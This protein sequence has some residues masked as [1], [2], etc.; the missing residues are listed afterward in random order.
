MWAGFL[1]VSGSVFVSGVVY[2]PNLRSKDP[3][4]WVGFWKRFF[5][6]VDCLQNC[7]GVFTGARDLLSIPQSGEKMSRRLGEIL[8]CQDKKNSSRYL[9]GFPDGSNNGSRV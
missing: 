2:V 4:Q 7:A 9:N 1:C 8:G 5:A 3:W 6:A